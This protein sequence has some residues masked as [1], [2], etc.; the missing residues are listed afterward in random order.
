MHQAPPE[1]DWG[2]PDGAGEIWLVLAVI[3]WIVLGRL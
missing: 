3:L 1:P 2:T